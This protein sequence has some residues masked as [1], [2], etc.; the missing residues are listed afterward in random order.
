MNKGSPECLMVLQLLPFFN[1]F[2]TVQ[3]AMIYVGEAYCG[4]VVCVPFDLWKL[5]GDVWSVAIFLSVS[6]RTQVS[7]LQ[8]VSD[9]S[10]QRCKPK[11]LG[12]DRSIKAFMCQKETFRKVC[13]QVYYDQ[14]VLCVYFFSVNICLLLK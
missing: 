14:P 5:E 10:Y 1:I 6:S 11:P 7:I 12:Y 3:E 8:L 13:L 2:Y 9:H 4:C